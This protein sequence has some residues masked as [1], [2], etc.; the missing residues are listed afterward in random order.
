MIYRKL[1]WTVEKKLV[2]GLSGD[3]DISSVAPADKKRLCCYP[4]VG[5]LG[6]CLDILRFGAWYVILGREIDTK[7]LF[8]IIF[9]LCLAHI[10]LNF[11][12]LRHT[13]LG[14]KICILSRIFSL[15]LNCLDQSIL[16][17]KLGLSHHRFLFDL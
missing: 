11:S 13:F 2:G 12:L 15:I 7:S 8:L 9:S 6:N 17:L 5:S 4:D 14:Q 3:M 16:G 10:C 1:R